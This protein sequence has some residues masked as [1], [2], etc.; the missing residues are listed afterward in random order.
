LKKTEH[1]ATPKH[2]GNLKRFLRDLHRGHEKEEKDKERAKAEVA[3]LNGMGGGES[4]SSSSSGFGRGPTPSIPKPPKPQATEADRKRQL[5]QLA[6]MGI[7]IPSEFRPDMALAGGWEVVSQRI[8][9]EDDG[10]KKPEAIAL[11]VRKRQVEEEDEEALE[12][13]KKRYGSS[14]RTHPT[15]EDQG[16]LDALLNNITRRGK[17][18]ALKSETDIGIK[19]ELKTETETETLP[20]NG[21][22]SSEDQISAVIKKEESDGIGAIAAV[23]DLKQEGKE[24]LATGIVF[25]KRKAKNIRQK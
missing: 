22:P 10:E 4:A 19:Q 15:E 12:A 6:E 3:R 16:D 25:K 7:D 2:Q 24:S 9:E 18:P 17:E 21:I 5:A 14:Y 8:I 23:P 11:G 13:K 20:R 1:D